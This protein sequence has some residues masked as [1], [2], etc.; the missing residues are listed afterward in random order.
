MDGVPCGVL[1]KGC[2]IFDTAGTLTFGQVH[3]LSCRRTERIL[4]TEDD[5]LAPT[6]A[7][8][9]VPN[10][11]IQ[12]NLPQESLE[13]MIPDS[14]L[15]VTL[16]DT[17]LEVT[18]VGGSFGLPTSSQGIAPSNVATD[19]VRKCMLDDVNGNMT[20]L[21]KYVKACVIEVSGGFVSSVELGAFTDESL[22]VIYN[23]ANPVDP[24][25]LGDTPKLL[26]GRK[27]VQD[28][29]WSPNALIKAYSVV[30][31][32]VGNV[33]EG[34]TYTDSFGNVTPLPLSVEANFGHEMDVLD[35]SPVVTVPSDSRVLI[36]YTQIG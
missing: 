33:S 8:I 32:Q 21:V 10:G 30:A 31:I 11:A 23:P 26:Q 3:D 20:E 12:V 5:I 14:A 7:D 6:G 13:V 4:I 27:E 24:E 34:P 15:Q 9:V 16:P 28:G 17:P 1:T 2:R 36:T 29:T 22:K 25:S 35:D 19:I 18:V